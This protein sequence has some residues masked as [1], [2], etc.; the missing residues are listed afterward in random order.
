[1]ILDA[2]TISVIVSGCIAVSALL[3]PGLLNLLLENRKWLREKKSN[4]IELINKATSSLMNVLSDL[5]VNN[6]DLGSHIR[7]GKR[8]DEYQLKSKSLSYFYEWERTVWIH[9]TKEDQETIKRIRKDFET[10]KLLKDDKEFRFAL[11]ND[12]HEITYRAIAK[13]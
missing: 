8:L 10:D 7:E 12:L 3:I 13:I 11:S 9:S 5:W 6:Y 2:S 1:M 4:E